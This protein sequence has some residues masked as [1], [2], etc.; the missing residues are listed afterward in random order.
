MCRG[1]GF[2]FCRLASI[3]PQSPPAILLPL[4]LFT[5]AR[6][7]KRYGYGL[8]LGLPALISVLMLELIVFREEPFFSGIATS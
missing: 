5:F 2:F 1:I 4:G 7:L 8:L 6:L 3:S